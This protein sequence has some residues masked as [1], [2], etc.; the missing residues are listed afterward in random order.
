MNKTSKILILFLLIVSIAAGTTMI[1]KNWNKV[2]GNNTQSSVKAPAFQT[3]YTKTESLAPVDFEKAATAAVPSVVHIK[4]V[5]NTSSARADLIPMRLAK[6]PRS[7]R[8]VKSSASTCHENR[9]M[10]SGN[11]GWR[12]PRLRTLW[13][14]VLRRPNR[15]I[16]QSTPSNWPS[17][18][19]PST[20]GI[21]S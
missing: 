14:S 3:A 17:C 5:I 11:C 15:R 21:P 9:E 10:K 18:L 8:R 7:T 6:I 19:T 13:I 12:R 4:T 16:W 20:T 1:L 2:Y